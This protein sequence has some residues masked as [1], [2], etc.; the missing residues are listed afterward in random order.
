[1]SLRGHNLRGSARF[2]LPYLRFES[3][4]ITRSVGFNLQNHRMVCCLCYNP[5]TAAKTA[6]VIATAP[7]GGQS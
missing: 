2:L 6:D 7:T 5:I 1:M 3:N 4:E